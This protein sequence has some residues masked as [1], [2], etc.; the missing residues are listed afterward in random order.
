[1]GTLVSDKHH[2]SMGPLGQKPWSGDD[3]IPWS[4]EHL[5]SRTTLMVNP[6]SMYLNNRFVDDMLHSFTLY[7]P[8]PQ[9]C[10]APVLWGAGYTSTVCWWTLDCA[11]MRS[12]LFSVWVSDKSWFDGS[13]F[14]GCQWCISIPSLPFGVQ[15]IISDLIV[16]ALQSGKCIHLQISAT[17]WGGLG[18]QY[19]LP[20]RIFLFKQEGLCPPFCI[21]NHFVV[22]S[23]QI[24]IFIL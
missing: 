24:I 6:Y 4:R 12:P 16:Q 20:A 22:D 14:L 3:L 8:H 9:F 2:G 5:P 13:V 23:F 17:K 21:W 7:A 11:W 19:R 10:A 18:L 1:M 15:E